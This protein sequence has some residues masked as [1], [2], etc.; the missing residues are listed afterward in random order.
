MNMSVLLS[1]FDKSPNHGFT[2][3]GW[4]FTSGDIVDSMRGH[5]MLNPAVELGTNACPWNC[6]FCFTEDPSNP[7][8][9]K[10]RLENELSIERRLRLIDELAELGSRSINFVGAG[11]PTI[12][13]N[14]WQLVDRMCERNITPIIYTEGTLRL[15]NDDFAKRLF[16]TGATVVLKM[17]SLTNSE[18]QNEIVAGTRSKGQIPSFDYTTERNKVLESLL[19]MG[20]A[21]STPTRLAFDTIVTRRNI[22]E[23]EDL[24]RFARTNNI[25][26]LL[27]NYLPSGR[28]SNL[29]D[30]AITREEQHALFKRLADID[31]QE[32]G[33]EHATCFAYGGG[34]PCSIRGLGMFVKITGEV[35]DCP[36]ESRRL[37]DLSDLPLAAIWEQARDLSQ[38]FDGLCFPREQFWRRLAQVTDSNQQ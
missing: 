24:H 23:I 6:S 35:F 36:G 11:E 38:G 29:Q 20:F 19:E 15:R 37:G 3:H 14:F 32:F 28:S 21:R 5:R 22:S 17:N 4:A 26:V 31:V 34:V 33:L 1:S 7:D 25:F 12:D 13:P 2:M 10:R 30:D 8:G 18:Y 27:V 16:D 9:R